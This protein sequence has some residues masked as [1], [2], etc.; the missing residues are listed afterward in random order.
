M[1][2]LLIK[3]ALHRVTDNRW[4]D[5]VDNRF[6]GSEPQGESYESGELCK[7]AEDK[8]RILAEDLISRNF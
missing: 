8:H 3:N 6:S 5:T 1:T 4:R 7:Q 2:A